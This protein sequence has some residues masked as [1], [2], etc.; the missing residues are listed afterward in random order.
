MKKEAINNYKH[1]KAERVLLVLYT[2]KDGRQMVG[3][4]DI[5]SGREWI[6]VFNDCAKTMMDTGRYVDVVTEEEAAEA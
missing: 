3:G 2:D 6:D 1:I 4:R 5:D